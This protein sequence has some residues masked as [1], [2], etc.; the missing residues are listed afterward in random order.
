MSSIYEVWHFRVGRDDEEDCDDIKQSPQRLGVY[1]TEE[2]AQM[3]IGRLKGGPE[4]ANWPNGFR[5]Y[6]RELETD[7]WE[8]GFVTYYYPDED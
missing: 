8:E 7:H 1:S 5:V 6:E 2:N 3:A 4:F